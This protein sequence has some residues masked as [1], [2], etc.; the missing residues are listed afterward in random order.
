MPPGWRK[1]QRAQIQFLLRDGGLLDFGD[2]GGGTARRT[3]SFASPSVLLA[4]T[5]DPALDLVVHT[6]PAAPARSGRGGV[7]HAGA[8]G[9]G[10]ATAST[11]WRRHLPMLAFLIAIAVLIA[12]AARPQPEHVAVPVTNGAIMIAQDVS[13]TR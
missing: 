4:A 13:R 2:P 7:R 8:H 9:V 3:M 10:G 5:R 12:A 6:A 1:Q 11:R